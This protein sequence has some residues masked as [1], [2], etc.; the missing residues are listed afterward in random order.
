MRVLWFQTTRTAS[1]EEAA[2]ME[3]FLA[4]AYAARPI[5][6]ES[7]P[8]KT[9]RHCA[10]CGEKRWGLICLHCGR[11]YRVCCLAVV[12][13]TLSPD[14]N[15]QDFS[16]ASCPTCSD[17]EEYHK[18]GNSW[19]LGCTIRAVRD[20]CR[21]GQLELDLDPALMDVEPRSSDESVTPG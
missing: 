1:T 10:S 16:Q 5:A 3:A 2:D 20:N 15:G 14:G 19:T 9:P 6:D 13:Y 17:M 12:A 18:R 21:D 7:E 4:I 8:P 11:V